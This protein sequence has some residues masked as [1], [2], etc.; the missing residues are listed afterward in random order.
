MTAVTTS[1]LG[2]ADMTFASRPDS[3]GRPDWRARWAP[4]TVPEDASDTALGIMAGP[5]LVLAFQDTTTVVQRV[6]VDESDD[7]SDEDFE[8]LLDIRSRLGQEIL[9]RLLE[10]EYQAEYRRLRERGVRR[11]TEQPRQPTGQSGQQG[12]HTG[13]RL[14]EGGPRAL[15]GTSS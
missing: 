9:R 1:D 5:A 3:D 11:P 15:G 2:Y 10:V 13:P 6:A 8:I 12:Q 4:Y 7:V 14:G